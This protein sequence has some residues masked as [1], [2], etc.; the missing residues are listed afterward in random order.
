MCEYNLWV[1][2]C[3]VMMVISM[4]GNVVLIMLSIMFWKASRITQTVRDS[5]E[6]LQGAARILR[7]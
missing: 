2:V 7:R 4:I 6:L 1:T 3:F 5:S